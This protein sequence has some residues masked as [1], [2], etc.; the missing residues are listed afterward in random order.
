MVQESYFDKVD[1]PS[2]GSYYIETLTKQLGDK[3]MELF[4]NIE[5]SGGFLKQLKE[6]TI[7]RKIKESAAKEQQLF[8]GGKE[9][10]LGSNKHP[11]DKDRMKHELELFPFVKTNQRKTLIEPIIEKRLSE[12]LE[13]ERLKKED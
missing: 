6:G 11:N 4:K 3:S 13:Q 1:N 10:L 8:D 7:Q 12:K 5:A 9:I 2:D